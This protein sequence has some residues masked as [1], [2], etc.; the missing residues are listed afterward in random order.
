[1]SFGGLKNQW[2][3][4]MFTRMSIA[5]GLSRCADEEATKPARSVPRRWWRIHRLASRML[6]VITMG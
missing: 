6:R 5:W 3:G 2:T 4:S 1:M